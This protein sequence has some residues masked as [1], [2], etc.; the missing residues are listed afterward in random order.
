MRRLWKTAGAAA[1]CIA[2]GGATESGLWLADRRPQLAL[3]SDT[4]IS[5]LGPR[6]LTPIVL[7][8][9]AEIAK[10]SPYGQ[11]GKTGKDFVSAWA[12]SYTG[13]A[14]VQLYSLTGDPALVE[15]LLT[16]WQRFDEAGNRYA[17]RDGYGW[18]SGS[19]VSDQRFRE[20]AIAGLI[21]Q[22]IVSL[23]LEAKRDPA[24]AALLAPDQDRLLATVASGMTGLDSLIL[25]R[26]GKS[27]AMNMARR[28]PEPTNLMAEYVV[29]RQGLAQ[30]TGST[31]FDQQ[32]AS[33]ARTVKASWR[34]SP[35]GNLGWP[36]FAT[37]SGLTTKP[38]PINKS[39]GTLTLI[40]TAYRA[41]IV[42]T[43]DDLTAMVRALDTTALIWR[44]DDAI[45]LRWA[46][47][48][49]AYVLDLATPAARHLALQL[50]GWY[51]LSCRSPRIAKTLNRLLPAL[52]KNFSHNS[53][54]LAGLTEHW[55]NQA[56]PDRCQAPARR[57]ASK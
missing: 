52:D 14:A 56:Q 23:L 40:M 10:R 22:P 24:L 30:L 6:D 54:V 53:F 31:D 39:P 3:S 12:W 8:K 27:W 57:V 36:Y 2:I 29:A 34:T 4:A 20:A 21:V 45:S 13:R 48:D 1:M 51:A 7:A 17:E 37:P 25:D 44:G 42:F 55:L 15:G 18:Y 19:I 38:E 28:G 26:D 35:A 41:G 50:S 33:L 43:D 5:R 16:A 46:M 32:F 9:L 47:D 11:Y 49:D